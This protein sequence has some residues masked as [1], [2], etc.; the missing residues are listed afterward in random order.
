MKKNNNNKKKK[1]DRF[2][3][4]LSMQ[5]N[6]EQ[7]TDNGVP[8]EYPNGPLFAARPWMRSA[9]CLSRYRGTNDCTQL[10][11]THGCN[12]RPGYTEANKT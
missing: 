6:L 2:N 1:I 11:L 7:V 10:K 12:P 4:S 9:R 8:T 3:A 5:L